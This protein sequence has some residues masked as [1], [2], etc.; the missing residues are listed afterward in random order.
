[1]KLSMNLLLWTDT[2]SS[3]KLPLLDQM[4]AIG[5]DGVELPM[6]DRDTVN[7]AAWGKA[8]DNLALIRTG[9]CAFGPDDH[10]ISS[11]AKVRR[12]AVDSI[13]Q[14]LDCCAAAGC[15]TMVGHATQALGVFTGNGP[16]AD[17]WKWARDGIREA[18]EHAQKVGVKI[19]LEALNRFECYFINSMADM[20]RFVDD[21]NH[22]YCRAMYDTF[23]AN[24]EEKSP[25][26]AL[27]TI[28]DHLIHVHISESDRSTPGT[29]M[30]HW[31]ETFDALRKIGYDGILCCEAFGLALP[32]LSAAT[33]IWRR[34]YTSEEQ[35]ARDVYKFMKEN[36]A[37]RW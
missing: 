34:M 28:K 11:D 8:L 6:F 33:K 2:L 17:E 3:D 14:T 16:T 35:L 18:S 30:V 13:K 15:Q 19:A 23:H 1:M 32:K 37:K 7:A 27:A 26:A 9:T 20:K 4:K 29:G 24:I 36:V 10:L 31:D 12:H 22:P 25:Q 21:V 5:F